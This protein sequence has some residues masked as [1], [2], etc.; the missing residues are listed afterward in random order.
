[1][2]DRKPP[3]DPDGATGACEALAALAGRPAVIT[4]DLH[5]GHLDTEVATLPLPPDRCGALVEHCAKL[6]DGFRS[7][8][9]PVIH[10]ITAYR[11]RD[12]ILS[13]RYWRFQADRPGSS[14]TRI[15]DHNLED[16]PGVE[17]M[18][19]L[20]VDGDVLVKTKKR[21]DC[22]VGTDLKQVLRAGEHDSVLILGVNT[23]SCVI[24]TA[25]A[26][27]VHDYAVFVLE[28]GVDSM[29]G[30]ELHEAALAVIETSFGWVIEGE[31]ALEIVGAEAG[32][33]TTA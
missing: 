4:I 31:A 14:R 19:G 3:R 30:P 15:A 11:S 24:A 10:V 1:M 5:R 13:N 27:S 8:G 20:L 6:L 12:E 16:G 18:P 29:L 2:V 25:I 28:D 9:V 32:R 7:A 33:S 17:L 21:Y 26:A 22:F 23:N